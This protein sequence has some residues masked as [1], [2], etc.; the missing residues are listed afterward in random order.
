MRQQTIFVINSGSSSLKYQLIEPVSG[1]VLAKGQAERIGTDRGEVTHEVHADKF[2]ETLPLPT[3]KEALTRIIEMFSTHGPD[4]AHVD[5]SGFGHRIVQGGWHFKGPAIVNDDV[6]AKIEELCDLA[7]LHNPA[8]LI[9]I[10]TAMELWPDLPHV[11][12]FDTAY[13]AGLPEKAR[14]YA[15]NKQVAHDYHIRRYGAHGTSH[16]FVAN[17]VCDYLGDDTV[18]QITLHL[19]N[20]A[21]ACAELGRLPMDTSMG[22]TPL[23]GLVMG[24]R[25]GDIDPAVVFHLLRKGMSVE[26]VD[27]LFNKESGMKGM[28]GDNDMRDVWKRRDEGDSDALLALQTY[29][30]RLLKYIGAYTFELG[31]LDVLTFT[32]GIGENDDRTRRRLCEK[33][34]FIGVKIDRERN[35]NRDRSKAIWRISSDDS[36]VLVLVVPTNE[37]LAIA[38]QVV[39]LI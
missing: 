21:S 19:G 17:K 29:Q 11:A 33:L 36:K 8:H 6:R 3:H 7:P 38:R 39:R 37:E 4:L 9:G 5:L 12:V 25:T 22:L 13:F 10:D 30:Q 34:E 14:S 23:E 26:D 15:L 28:C 35:E 1:D 2:S 27:T 24:T 20:G 32:A 16:E 18:K 31:G